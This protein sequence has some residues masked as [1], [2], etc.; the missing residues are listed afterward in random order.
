MA[1]TVGLLLLGVVL[2]IGAGEALVRISTADQ[3]NYV[4]EMWRY[5]KLLKRPSDDP[6]IGHEH[7]PNRTAQ[8]QNVE[9][10]INSLGMRGPEPKAD[11]HRRIAIIGDS[12]ALGWGLSDTESLRGQLQAA[13]PDDVDVVNDGVGNMN[14]SQISAHWARTNARLPVDTV[15]LLTSFRAPIQ[16][17]APTRNPILRN[18]ALSAILFTYAATLTSGASGRDDMVAAVRKEWTTGPGAAAMHKGFD[19]I[20]ALARARGYRVILAA[21]PEMHDLQNYPFEFITE[22]QRAEAVKHGWT[23][24]DLRPSLLGKS[25]EEYWVTEQDVH[26]NAAATTLVADRLLPLLTVD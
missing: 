17:P 13:L 26:L 18:S 8:L 15:I 10:S 9:I 1:G 21:V 3:R 7:V 6:A 19:Q 12:L 16:Q 23:F 2:A 25:A 4:V 20:A 11:A 14:L 24:V 5:A 22:I